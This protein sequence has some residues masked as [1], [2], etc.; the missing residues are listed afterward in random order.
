MNNDGYVK[1]ENLHFKK[2][3]TLPE[4][5]LHFASSKGGIVTYDLGVDV[6][7]WIDWMRGETHVRP[8]SDGYDYIFR[9][10]YSGLPNTEITSRPRRL[11]LHATT[12]PNATSTSH[13]E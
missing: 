2:G 4:S 6:E 11:V 9:I 3:D 1:G 10:D 5:V 12:A 8:I 13:G 7:V